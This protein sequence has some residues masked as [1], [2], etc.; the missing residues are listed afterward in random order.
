MT[1]NTKK[2]SKKKAEANNLRCKDKKQYYLN[3]L[4]LAQSFTRSDVLHAIFAINLH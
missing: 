4:H 3:T 2:E 1:T